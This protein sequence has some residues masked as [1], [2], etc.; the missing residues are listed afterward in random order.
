MSSDSYYNDENESDGDARID[1][2]VS[3]VNYGPWFT[4][5]DLNTF[6]ISRP[7]DLDASCGSVDFNNDLKPNDFFRKFL[8][9]EECCILN[10]IVEETNRYA[11]EC[12]KVE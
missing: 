12:L 10:V 4:V 9:K 5:V 2:L 11:D 3:T 1:D 6:S 8:N 7:S